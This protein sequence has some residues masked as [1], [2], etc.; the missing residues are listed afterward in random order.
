MWLH[1]SPAFPPC[2]ICSSLQCTVFP[3]V[4]CLCIQAC[5]HHVNASVCVC[6]MANKTGSCLLYVY[7]G[8]EHHS[9]HFQ[10][11]PLHS[12]YVTAEFVSTTAS[13]HVPHPV[14]MTMYQLTP[15]SLCSSP[16]SSRFSPSLS[17][18]CSKS[19]LN[20][21]LLSAVK[22]ISTSPLHLG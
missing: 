2:V 10:P 21:D 13:V 16:P 22:C 7:K 5:L 9:E 17:P 15:L 14:F 19:L 6:A 11:A 20:L 1:K 8:D 3:N 4:L 18:A 12:P